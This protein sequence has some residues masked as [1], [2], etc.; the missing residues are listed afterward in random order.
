MRVLVLTARD[1]TNPYLGGGELTFWEWSKELVRHGHHVEYLCSTFPGAERESW[2]DGIHVLRLADEHFLGL[3]AFLSYRRKFKNRVDV[4]L[5]DIL[6]GSRVPFCAP[7]YVKEPVIGVWHQDHLPLFR[8]QYGPLLV[9]AL[10]LLERWL[11]RIHRDGAT[12]CPS[13]ESRNSLIGKGGNSKTILIY[14]PGISP[15]IALSGPPLPFEARKPR[16]V[17][18]GKIRRYKSADKAIESF[19]R[20]LPR[21]PEA[22]LV[23]AG[24]MGQAGYVEELK[25]LV[26]RL[27]LDERVRI[28]IDI[29]EGRKIELLRTSRALIA[30]APVE[31][32]GVALIE[33]GACGLPVVGTEGIPVAALREDFNGFRVAPDDVD[34]MADRLLKLLT[35]PTV[36]HRLSSNAYQY[37]RTFDWSGSAVPL[38]TL[39]RGGGKSSPL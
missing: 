31:G 28:E 25:K 22:E 9:P 13:E 12:L 19:A 17:C 10:S 3:A 36:F 5:E 27:G 29:S 20:I 4:V 24:R 11:V 34:T 18:L 35:D 15:E 30:P 23:V 16:V 33:A 39:V 7:L 14:R 37:S 32:F 6:G 26:N 8:K 1:V 21:M 38:L 2:I